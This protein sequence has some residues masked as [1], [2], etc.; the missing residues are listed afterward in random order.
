MCGSLC[1]DHILELGCAYCCF[2]C[3]AHFGEIR[4]T[5]SGHVS[6]KTGYIIQQGCI[7]RLDMNALCMLWCVS[8]IDRIIIFECRIWWIYP[9][10]ILSNATMGTQDKFLEFR[11]LFR[12]WI[13]HV[14]GRCISLS[15]HGFN[16]LNHMSVFACIGMSKKTD[17]VLFVSEPV[18]LSLGLLW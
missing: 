5:Y 10:N 17:V 12:K 4:V 9:D 8:G 7:F 13:W 14:Q 16:R 1:P 3:A 18:A 11:S 15:E 6:L 2:W